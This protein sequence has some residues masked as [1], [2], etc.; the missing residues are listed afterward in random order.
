[1]SAGRDPYGGSVD[2]D[3]AL[4]LLAPAYAEAIRLDDAGADFGE[5]ARVLHTEP[6]AVPPLLQ[7]GRAKLAALLAAG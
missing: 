1:M 4:D 7:I 2:I 3:D 5:I 6:E